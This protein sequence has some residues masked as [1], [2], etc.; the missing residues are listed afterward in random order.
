MA[1]LDFWIGAKSAATRRRIAGVTLKFVH[2][3]L[4]SEY[5][6]SDGIV[7]IDDAV[8]R[9]GADRMPALALTDLANVFGL[10]K[11]YQA[12]RAGGIK[13]IVGCDVW[14]TNTQDR[15]KPHR[16]LLLCQ[17]RKGY[18]RLF[19]LLTR[20]YRSNQHRGRAELAKE[21][22]HESGS[23]GLIALSGAHHG[24]IGQALLAGNITS[25]GQL[26]RGWAELFPQRFYLEVQRAGHSEDEPHLRRTVRLAA[27][28]RLPVVATHPV[29]FLTPEEFK[30]HEARVCISQGYILANQRRPRLFTAE[31]YLKTQAEMAQLFAD[32]PAALANS[33]E[34]AKRCN[35]ELE[36]GKSKLPQFPTPDGQSLD[37]YL[38]DQSAAGLALR[39]QQLY[40]EAQQRAAQEQR[41]RDRLAL[42][43]DTIINMGF[44]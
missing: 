27:N 38:R 4:H 35:F 32:L 18:L 5:S 22:F 33:V 1:R 19:E 17:N 11:F 20:A 31:Q 10:V 2:L 6:V 39:L 25:A 41:Y 29:Q 7:R 28:L 23:E 30:A 13:P 24:D 26:A 36:L 15:D 42:E 9:A 3:R 37:A 12:A 8:A 40:A 21:W 16:L 43:L 44:A 14:I 34:I